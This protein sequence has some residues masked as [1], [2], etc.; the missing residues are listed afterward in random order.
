M[1]DDVATPLNPPVAPVE[2]EE[3]EEAL[4]DVIISQRPR[5]EEP[6]RHSSRSF[7]MR[8]SIFS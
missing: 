8:S 5:E 6:P 1:A 7:D 3:L 2:Q 4:I